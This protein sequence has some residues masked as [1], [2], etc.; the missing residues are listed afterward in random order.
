MVPGGY[1]G[2]PP[3]SGTKWVLEDP[4]R[5]IKLSLKGLMGP[6]EV[7][8][9][10]YPGQ[11]PMTAFGGLL[12][13]EEMAAV[14][15]YVRNSFGNRASAIEAEQVKKIRTEIKDQVDLLSP[16]ELLKKHPH[17]EK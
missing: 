8:G 10:K 1:A 4:D 5:L 14:L 3:L 13:D 9:K 17:A 16:D 15:T 7:K 11:L 2:F 12:N 6:I